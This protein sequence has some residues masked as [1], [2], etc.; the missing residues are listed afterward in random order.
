MDV[1]GNMSVTVKGRIIECTLAGSFNLEGCERYVLA[2]KESIEK[3]NGESFAM[4]IDDLAFEGAT[5]EA[6]QLFN[7]YNL[8]MNQQ[9][10]VA[11]ALIMESLAKKEIL[12]KQAPEFAK[13]NLEFFTNVD[14]A[15]QWLTQQLAE[16]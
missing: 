10:L 8:W 3:L 6:Y 2:V 15:M 16:A 13:Q 5:P 7:E 4:L 1:H 12:L 9:P 14:D 11:K